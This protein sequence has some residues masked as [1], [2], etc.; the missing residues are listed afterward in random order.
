MPDIMKNNY[1]EAKK[2]ERRDF[3]MQKSRIASIAYSIKNEKSGNT[4]I[5]SPKF[6]KI[7]EFIE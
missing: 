1:K 7:K 5:I 2:M 6:Q 3:F 4:T